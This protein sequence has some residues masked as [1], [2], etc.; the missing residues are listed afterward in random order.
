MKL[1]IVRFPIHA[2]GSPEVPPQGPLN[3]QRVCLNPHKH[4]LRASE[5]YLGIGKTHGERNR[6]GIEQAG[7]FHFTS[8]VAELQR[9][10]LV[11]S[12]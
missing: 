2:R 3:G 10:H 1:S 8:E 5:L 4:Y 6:L 9:D 12:E 11:W 7:K